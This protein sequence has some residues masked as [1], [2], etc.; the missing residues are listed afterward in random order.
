MRSSLRSPKS[1]GASP[2]VQP[3]QRGAAC[4]PVDRPAVIRVDEAERLELVALVDVG[5]AGHRQLEQQ[6]AQRRTPTLHRDALGEGDEPIG[7]ALD[8]TPRVTARRRLVGLVGLR[9]RRAQLG[10]AQRLLDVRLQALGLDRPGA[11]E[12]LQDQVGAVLVGRVCLADP[13]LGQRRPLLGHRAERADPRAHVAR[14]LRVVGLGHE[15][16]AREALGPRRVGGV[17]GVDREPEARRVAADL[18]EREQPQVAIEGGV[19]DP[20]RGDRRRGLLKARDELVV[21]ALA[22]RQHVGEATVG[23]DLDRAHVVL[24]HPPRPRL[25]VGAVDGQRRQR[26]GDAVDVEQLAQPLHLAREGGRRL[27]ELRAR[28]HLVER[29][30]GVRQPRERRLPRRVD[31]QRGGVVEELVADGALDG[32]VAQRLCRCAGSSRPT[33][34]LPRRRAGAPGSPPGRRARRGG[35]RAA[36]RRRRR[37]RARGPCRGRARRPRGPRRARRPGRRCR[38]SAGTS[39]RR[40]RSRRPARARARRPTSGSR[41]TT[42]MWLGTMSSTIS[43]ALAGQGAQPLLPTERV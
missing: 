14:A 40:G 29:L 35:R 6:L 12:R 3:R 23:G 17:E 32:P 30:A 1:R 11:D 22:Q 33:R 4:L 43:K 28:R 5:H 20:L 34:A 36:R 39:R 7:R 15:Q 42:P 38:R 31:E 19:L 13:P 8:E 9:P 25:H 18:V 10:L 27:L 37:A 16:P 26:L 21:A 24:L 2:A 41:R